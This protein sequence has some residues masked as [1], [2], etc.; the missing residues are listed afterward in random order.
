MPSTA[1]LGSMVQTN[2][3]LNKRD[4]KTPRWQGLMSFT[5][6]GSLGDSLLK[7]ERGRVLRSTVRG[8]GSVK[9]PYAVCGDKIESLK[10][11]SAGVERFIASSSFSQ[12]VLT[13]S[14]VLEYG[15]AERGT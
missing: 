1:I 15:W 5:I 2:N 13:D 6:Q 11:S 9:G 7:L 8:I 14:H 12:M 3:P 4:I 10:G